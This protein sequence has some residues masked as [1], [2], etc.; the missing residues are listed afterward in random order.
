MS[1][2]RVVGTINESDQYECEANRSALLTRGRDATRLSSADHFLKRA[3]LD[4]LDDRVPAHVAASAVMRYKSI[5]ASQDTVA[6]GLP[7]KNER[8][9]RCEMSDRDVHQ[10]STS[11]TI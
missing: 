2:T 9:D 6:D 8:T 5:R 10:T 7:Q 3:C 11:C 1:A 4:R